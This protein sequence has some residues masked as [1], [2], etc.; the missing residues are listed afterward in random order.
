[1]IVAGTGTEVGKTYVTAR[2][3]AA[4]RA[5]GIDVA[6][7]KPVQSNTADDLQTDADLLAAATGEDPLVVCPPHRRYLLAMAPP[8]AADA[9]GR[10]PFTISDLTAEITANAPDDALTFVE[11][12]GGV[13]SPL[14][15]DGDTVALAEALQPALVVLVAD[16]GLGTINAVH[17]SVDALSGLRVVVFLNRFDPGNDLHRRNRDWLVTR[18]GLEVVTDLE[19][20]ERVVAAVLAT[21][22]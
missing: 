6:A 14:T 3:A 18:S 11:S 22:G 1:V 4:L 19:T 20:L 13:R 15:T 16:A 10:P 17:L 21:S 2:L 8:M 9:L 12:A 7:R 5:Q